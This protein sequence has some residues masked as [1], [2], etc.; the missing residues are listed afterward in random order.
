MNF[1]F[2]QTRTARKFLR[3]KLALGASFIIAIYF[4]FA[5]L[6]M[7]GLITLPQTEERI[8]PKHI[9]GFLRSR[10]SRGSS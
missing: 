3:N 4:V 5:A 6:V 2:L 7:C 1:G 8:G 10:S 9:P